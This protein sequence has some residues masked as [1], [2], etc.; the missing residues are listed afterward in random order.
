MGAVILL[1]PSGDRRG[2]VK[3]AS[4]ELLQEFHLKHMVYV[5][6]KTDVRTVSES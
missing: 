6:S 4:G 1:F 2:Q 3:E 5:G